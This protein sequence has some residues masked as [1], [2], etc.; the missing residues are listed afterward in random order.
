MPVE[1]VIFNPLEDYT[2]KFKAMHEQKTTAFFQSLVA[3]SGVDIEQNR[4]TVTAY[5]DCKNNTKKLKRTY[6]W[7]RFLRVVMIITILL[8]PLVI[9]K[10]TPKI[11]ALRSTIEQTETRAA[12]L[13][14]EAHAQM[15]PLNSLFT[16]R[17]AL[18]LVQET[19]P[20][21]SFDD[22]LSA[23]RELDMMVNYDFDD[24][25]NEQSTLNVIAGQYNENPFIFQ[26]KL[27][28]T[29]G[30]ET[31]HGHLTIHWTETYRDSEGRVRTRTRTQTLHASVVKPKPYY[32]T[33]VV[34]HYGAQGAPNL[35]FSRSASH[36]EQ[37]SEREVEKHIKKGEKKLKKMTDKA[38]KKNDDFMSMSNTDFE[39]LFNAL[40]RTDEVGFRTLFTP[41]A[42]TN[43]VDLILSKDTYGDDFYFLKQHRMNT[44][45]SNHSQGRLIN[46]LPHHYASYS[47]DHIQQNFEGK[48][49]EFFKAVYFDFAPLL[50]IPAYQERPVHSLQPLPDYNRKYSRQECETLANM[51]ASHYVVHPDTKTQAILKADILGSADNVDEARITAYSYDII[52]QVDFIPVL[53]GDGRHHMVPV[54]WDDYIPLEAAANFR[55]TTPET[56]QN[57]AILAG[58]DTLCIF[59]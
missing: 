59:Q 21:L 25:N 19:I 20:L 45:V 36:M 37:K 49:R 32:S 31:Y 40:D 12:T 42:Q 54:P 51:M 56:A 26:N 13:L 9:W 4:K 52:P 57:A 23:E 6:N 38:I 11:K 33:Q 30:V 22:H 27:I 46:L 17:D 18:N 14:E 41:L 44:I 10:I 53:G 43:M 2:T 8:I 47:Y 34:L 48:N 16:S 15:L 28:H 3:Q 58:K 5:E 39:V 35:S 24:H 55:I 50:A 1:T 29:M 7:W